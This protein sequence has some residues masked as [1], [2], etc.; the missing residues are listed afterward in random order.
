MQCRYAGQYVATQNSRVVVHDRKGD[1][2]F[3]KLEEKGINPTKVTIAF[4]PPKKTFFSLHA[5]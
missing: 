5:G 3:K 4:I 2:L 1:K